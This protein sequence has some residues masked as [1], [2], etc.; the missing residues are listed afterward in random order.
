M[1]VQLVFVFASPSVL[2]TMPS[3]SV[4]LEFF[5]S[6]KTLARSVALWTLTIGLW[7]SDERLASILVGLKVAV[8]LEA[9]K[10]SGCVPG[11]ETWSSKQWWPCVRFGHGKP[12][13]FL[14]KYIFYFRT[15]RV[16]SSYEDRSGHIGLVWAEVWRTQQWTET[17][18]WGGRGTMINKKPE[19]SRVLNKNKRNL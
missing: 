16:R 1:V 5:S 8:A 13:G 9:E 18:S 15:N 3:A 2:F 10:G 7:M 11:L 14:K 17:V 12:W 19:Q 6:K 4:W